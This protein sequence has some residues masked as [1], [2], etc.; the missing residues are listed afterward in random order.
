MTMPQAAHKNNVILSMFKRA[1]N[2]YLGDK[3]RPVYMGIDLK[4][5]LTHVGTGLQEDTSDGE[6]RLVFI[7]LT[8]EQE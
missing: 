6:W 7:R 4:T 1:V 2:A 8:N 5:N 3:D